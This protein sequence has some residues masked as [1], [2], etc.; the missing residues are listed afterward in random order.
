MF[1]AWMGFHAVARSTKVPH[2][3]GDDTKCQQSRDSQVVPIED[4]ALANLPIDRKW[5]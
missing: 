5:R 2:N 1:T 3:V 4:L